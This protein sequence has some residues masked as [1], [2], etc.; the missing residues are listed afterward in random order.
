[1][2]I[3]HERCAVPNDDTRR[4]EMHTI[5]ERRRVRRRWKMDEIERAHKGYAD[6]TRGAMGVQCVVK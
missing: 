1:M 6:A 5:E 4:A 2:H 3:R